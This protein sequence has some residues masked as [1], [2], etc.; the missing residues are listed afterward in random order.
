MQLL[1]ALMRKP[2]PYANANIGMKEQVAAM[3]AEPLTTKPPQPYANANIG[4]KEQVAAMPAEPLTTKPPQPPP[5]AIK[6]IGMKEQVAAMPAEPLMTK[7][8]PPRY[9][10][11]DAVR[12]KYN[13][14]MV[15]FAA[16]T[17]K[18]LENCERCC[19]CD[20]F[21]SSGHVMSDK[22]LSKLKE[23]S[24]LDCLLG[25]TS[26]PRRL[27]P[28]NFKPVRT[29]PKQ[30]LTRAMVRQHWGMDPEGLK[31][32]AAMRLATDMK[33]TV[34]VNTKPREVNPKDL[35]LLM[36]TFDGKKYRETDVAVPWAAVPEGTPPV[37]DSS[38]RGGRG[39][40]GSASSAAGSLENHQLAMPGLQEDDQVGMPGLQEDEPALQLQD[41][42]VLQQEAEWWPVLSIESFTCV[43]G[44]WIVVVCVYQWI[45]EGP[46]GWWVRIP[47]MRA[48]L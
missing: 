43:G 37:D 21:M 25:I 2:Q 13:A 40:T 15:K 17:A 4:M 48:R 1:G 10:P 24:Q 29:G 16:R 35:K 31:R 26:T 39:D 7:P 47:L 30:P 5:Y 6:N 32:W 34:S 27:T 46:V 22:H 36:V 3:P 42:S 20:K 23:H 45:W 14:D 38:T 8:P 28:Q 19:L 41:P 44:V 33:G 11:M 12:A 9:H 18:Q